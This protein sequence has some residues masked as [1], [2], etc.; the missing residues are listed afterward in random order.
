MRAILC[1]AY[2]NPEILRLEHVNPPEPGPEEVLVRVRAASVSIS[3][4][5]I[6][7]GRVKPVMW[8]PFRIFV[9]LRGP[10]NPILGLELSGEIEAVGARVAQWQPG[11]EIFAFTGRRFGAY[12]EYSC[13]RGGGRY[14]PSDCVMARKPSN[15]S[16]AEAATMPSRSML[17]LHFLERADARPGQRVL[18]YGASSGVGVFALQLA[19]HFG[20]RVTGVTGPA[21]TELARSLGADRVLDYTIDDSPE[22]GEAYDLIFDTL[23]AKK[24][25]ALK[26]RCLAALRP[27]GKFVSVDRA[28]R[29]SAGHLDTVRHLVEGGAIRPIVDRTYRLEEIVEAHRYVEAGHKGGGVAIEIV[30]P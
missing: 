6:R 4:C 7:S 11:D 10:R 18:I 20:A 24:M 27:G 15:I 29:I 16:H 25:S 21:H 2:G 19:K 5:V 1:P 26:S 28:V 14:M 8:I 30:S 23:G 9:G 13:L 12:A 22:I 17:A 3:D